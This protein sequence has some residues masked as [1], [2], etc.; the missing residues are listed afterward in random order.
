MVNVVI[1]VRTTKKSD[2]TKVGF[3]LID[4]REV[5]VFYTSDIFVNAKLWDQKRQTFKSTLF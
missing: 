5:N 4:G 2:L 1:F 3:R